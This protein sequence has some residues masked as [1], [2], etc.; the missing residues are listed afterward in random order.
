MSQNREQPF[1]TFDIIYQS[2]FGVDIRANIRAFFPPTWE[3]GRHSK[4]SKKSDNW[5]TKVTRPN[6]LTTDN[7]WLPDH[8]K[9][10]WVIRLIRLW[11]RKNSRKKP[12][13]DRPNENFWNRLKVLK[14]S[15]QNSNRPTEKLKFSAFYQEK[16][17]FLRIFP[18]NYQSITISDCSLLSRTQF[19]FHA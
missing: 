11:S 12:L 8:Q 15:D 13:S 19:I 4:Y 1:W 9:C 17:H 5:H 18:R 14:S 6:W 2:R 7:V 3:I 16:S 10:E